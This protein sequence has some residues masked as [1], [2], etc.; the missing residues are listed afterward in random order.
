MSQQQYVRAG[1]CTAGPSK[2]TRLVRCALEISDCPNGTHFWSANE[3]TTAL[4][5]EAAVCLQAAE[6][7]KVTAGM[8]GGG[9]SSSTVV[10]SCLVEDLQ[11]RDVYQ[12]VLNAQGCASGHEYKTAAQ[13]AAGGDVTCNLCGLDS[14]MDY[15]LSDVTANQ[16]VLQSL[17]G[18]SDDDTR[19]LEAVGIAGIVVGLIAGCCLLLCFQRL[20]RKCCGGRGEKATTTNSADDSDF[21]KP[22]E[23]A[24]EHTES[25]DMSETKD[26]V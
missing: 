26:I 24:S 6:T 21:A 5:A 25:A 23:Q 13:T 1:A 9:G 15:D 22:Q 8:C 16:N 10:G 19:Q 20:R 17:L 14:S 11:A 7:T 4:G 3:L 18:G 12:C 2:N